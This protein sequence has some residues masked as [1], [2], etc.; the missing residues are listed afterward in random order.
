MIQPILPTVVRLFG[1]EEVAG[2]AGAEG[3]EVE[4]IEVGGIEVEGVL[5]QAT[6]TSSPRRL[7]ANSRPCLIS[8]AIIGSSC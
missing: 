7:T 3:I 6:A 1:R 2:V 4:G 5:P 8:S